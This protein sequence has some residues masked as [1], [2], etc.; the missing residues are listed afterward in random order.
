MTNEI[1]AVETVALAK[2]VKKAA[3]DKARALLSVGEYHI[4]TTVEV[5]GT[6]TVGGD[7]EQEFW[8]IAK[9]EKTVLAL[10]C[11]LNKTT[12][13]KITQEQYDRVLSDV[14]GITNSIT[15]EQAKRFKSDREATLKKLRK[16]T[17][18][19]ANG[20][21]TTKITYKVVEQKAVEASAK[22]KVE[23]AKA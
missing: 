21:V 11:A 1:S 3:A 2:M 12:A 18:K 5:E 23:N 8:Q 14:E 15:D 13:D 19:M 6:M 16:P 22:A 20:K 9:P 7:Y 4:K 10:A 17:K